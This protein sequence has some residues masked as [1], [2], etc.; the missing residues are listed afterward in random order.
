[1]IQVGAVNIY[2][3]AFTRR[4]EKDASEN[5]DSMLST[6]NSSS[7]LSPSK[8]ILLSNTLTSSPK[9]PLAVAAVSEVMT[10]IHS[11]VQHG[12]SATSKSTPLE[13]SEVSEGSILSKGIPSSPEHIPRP[14]VLSSPVAHA[15]GVPSTIEKYLGISNDNG[16]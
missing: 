1:M 3:D 9:L 16:R 2:I 11:Q 7:N 14:P 4:W 5:I 12:S 15:V 13:V 10:N 6:T 8:F